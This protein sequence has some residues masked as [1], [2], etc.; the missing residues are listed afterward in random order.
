MT[1]LLFYRGVVQLE[2]RGIWKKKS[3][4]KILPILFT[5]SSYFLLINNGVFGSLVTRPALG[6]GQF[7]EFES[8]HPNQSRV[9]KYRRDFNPKLP[10]IKKRLILC[11]TYTAI[12]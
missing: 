9:W 2:E 5:K 12:F 1:F 6:A 7:R 10:F 4:P 8:H 3:Q 11:K